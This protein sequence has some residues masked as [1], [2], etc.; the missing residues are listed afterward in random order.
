MKLEDEIKSKFRNDYQKLAVNIIYTHSWLDTFFSKKFKE[1]GLTSQQFNILS[2][3]RGQHPQSA[4]I[5]LL[6]ER[7]LEKIPDVSRLVDRLVNKGFIDRALSK[8]D[9]RKVDITITKKGLTLLS[10]IDK[11]NDEF[12]SLLKSL[13]KTEASTLNELLDKLRNNK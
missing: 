12:D 10:K 3:L 9:R 6:K 5:G 8:E 1:H 11:I 2:I 4:T 7:M 13:N